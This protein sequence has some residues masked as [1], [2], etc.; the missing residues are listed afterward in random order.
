MNKIIF[1]LFSVLLFLFCATTEKEKVPTD[2]T[3]NEREILFHKIDPQKEKLQFFWKDK[4]GKKYKNIGNLIESL[5]T[6]NKEVLFG[7]NGGMFNKDLSPQ[8]LYIENGITKAPIDENEEGYGN[9]YLQPNGIF[10][11]TNEYEPIIC[12]TNDFENQNIKYATQSG[13]M[14]LIDGVIHSKLTKGSSNLHIRNGVGILPNGHLLFAMSKKK[15]NFYDFATFFQQNGCKN[16]LYLD[17][18][19]SKTYLPSKNWEQLDGKFGI[20]IAEMKEM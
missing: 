2:Y 20:I 7:M 1:L 3:I 5:K 10:A 4:H 12:T 19:V 13:P 6:E 16:A 9:F 15:I 11:L 17:G 14:L 18:F 8:G